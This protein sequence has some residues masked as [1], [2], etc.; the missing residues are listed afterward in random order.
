MSEETLDLLKTLSATPG[1][2]GRETLVQNI[3][4]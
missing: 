2:V 1:P 4:I 3:V